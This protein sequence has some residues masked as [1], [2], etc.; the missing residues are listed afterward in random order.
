MQ[1]KEELQGVGALPTDGE[2]QGASH[3]RVMIA[4]KSREERE[5]QQTSHQ[6]E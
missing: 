6:A 2:H 3:L 5:K 1:C 4:E